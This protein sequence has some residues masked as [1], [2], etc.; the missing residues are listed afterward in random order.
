MKEFTTTTIE[1][2]YVAGT[3]TIRDGMLV[4]GATSYS[5]K[6]LASGKWV[7]MD[8]G[9]IVKIYDYFYEAKA[10]MFRRSKRVHPDEEF[11]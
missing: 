9:L 8:N 5:I 6:K 4:K 2:E 11:I 7:L 3:D 10:A 1:N